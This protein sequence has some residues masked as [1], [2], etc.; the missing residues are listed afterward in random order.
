MLNIVQGM[1]GYFFTV[2]VPAMLRDSGASLATVSLAYVIWIPWALKWLWAPYFDN[3]AAAPFHSRVA[4]LRALPIMMAAVFLL[5]A[6]FPPGSQQWPL[7]A[8]SL[9]SAT[10]GAT[11]QVV[12]AAWLIEN[13]STKE[14]ALANAAQVA[15]VTLGGVFG[16][17]LILTLGDRYGWV[18]AIAVV[19]AIIA[20]LSFSTWF[21]KPATT[22]GS[23]AR[24]ARDGAWAAWKGLFVRPGFG[25]LLL[26]IVLAGG[27]AGA[28]ALLPAIMIDRGFTASEVGWIISTLGLGSILPASLLAGWLVRQKGAFVAIAC[29]YALK[30]LTLA[31]L[32]L[33]GALPP[34]GVAGL[35]VLDCAL[36]GALMVAT[37]QLYMGFADVEHAA[38]DYGLMTSL[39]AAF[40]LVGGLIAGQAGDALGYPTIFAGSAL[41]AALAVLCAL[42]FR[43]QLRPN[44]A[45]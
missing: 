26:L 29:L 9:L 23:F 24:K 17:G 30:G 14:R 2:G 19:S 40:R 42:A 5:V 13:S 28:D 3:P 36:S 33:S 21:E 39:E 31:A 12:L 38:T 27:A 16:G 25:R 44:E 32:A 43:P 1:P 11:L 7:I 45:T 15:G 18:G 10:V 22:A 8:I 6:F 4:W 35:V 41:A 20:G 34:V 37:Y